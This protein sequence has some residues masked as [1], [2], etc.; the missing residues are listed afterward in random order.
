LLPHTQEN[1]LILNDLWQTATLTTLEE[2]LD[3]IKPWLTFDPL[4]GS[5]DDFFSTCEI[6]PTTTTW[7]EQPGRPR[8]ALGPLAKSLGASLTVEDFPRQIVP[9]SLEAINTGGAYYTAGM[10][11]DHS[12]AKLVATCEWSGRRIRLHVCE[13]NEEDGASYLVVLENGD[14]PEVQIYILVEST[15][16]GWASGY[17]SWTQDGLHRY[18]LQHQTASSLGNFVQRYL[19]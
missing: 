11:V 18:E 2:T 16:V 8:V 10:V 7:H 13:P 3:V 5:Y 17:I 9:G 15:D 19:A 1:K 12:L 4:L 6:Y 14:L